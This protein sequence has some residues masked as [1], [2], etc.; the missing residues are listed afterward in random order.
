MRI[1]NINE[2]YYL[3]EIRAESMEQFQGG[4]TQSIGSITDKDIA[5]LT[6][7]LVEQVYKQKMNIVSQN[8]AI[9][10]GI[11]LPFESITTTKFNDII[12]NQSGVKDTPT[13]KG[14]AYITYTFHYIYR[15]DL[16]KAFITYL[17]ERPSEKIQVLNIDKSSIKFIKD[18]SSFEEGELK[19]NGT[20]LIIPTQINSI[21]GY[22]F[23]QDTNNILPEIK[24][25][26]AGK[27]VEEARS[28][29]LS[30]FPKEIGSVKITVAPLR[31]TS[32]PTIK[33]RIKIE[34][35]G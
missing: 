21:Q 3:K 33:S 28:Y 16:S 31:Y 14:T 20:T 22:D 5:T 19:K 34:I 32:I 11:L 29:M 27:G 6:G 12:V 26:I 17:N 10:D 1:R 24:T 9:P 15:K 23:S 4:S 13:I 18:S 7:K 25:T 2:S 30:T 35:Q 8:F